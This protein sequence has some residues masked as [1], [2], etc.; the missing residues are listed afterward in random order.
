VVLKPW[1]YARLAHRLKRVPGLIIRRQQ[2]PLF[3]SIAPAIAG[4][5]G[6]ETSPALRNQGIAYRPGATVGLSGLQ[7]AFQSQLAGTPTTRVITE[8]TAGRQVS[9]LA[10]WK[11]STPTAVR[12]TIDSAVQRAAADAVS[13]APGS[14]AVV[15]VQASTGRILAAAEHSARGLPQIDALAGHYPPGASFTIVSTEALLASGLAVTIPVRC[16]RVNDVGGRTFR[17]IPPEPSL[18]SQPPFAVDFAHACTTAFSGLSETLSA[19]ELNKAASGFR[20]GVP[21]RLPLPAFS[22]TVQAGGGVAKLASAAIGAGNVAM[23]PLAMALVAA[24]VDSGRSHPPSLVAKPADPPKASPLPFSPANIATLRLLMRGTVHTGAA[25]QADL[26]GP[27]VY[28]QV[29]TAALGSGSHHKWAT[30][31]VGYRG[32]LA[33]AVLEISSSPAASAVPTAA[34]FL[35]SS[36]LP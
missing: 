4:S 3:S 35:T 17:N 26:A 31:F 16:T 25:R 20:L 19:H 36:P 13:L 18:G 1:Q 30:W 6:T 24:G 10:T 2:L 21:W 27:P 14:A 32:D 11:G 12:T 33:F 28:G 8:N 5:V 7:Q 34:T 9:V 15:A 23:S 29:G 22:G